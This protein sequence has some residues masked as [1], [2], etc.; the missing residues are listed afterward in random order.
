M[1]RRR[2]VSTL[3][4]VPMILSALPVLGKDKKPEEPVPPPNQFIAKAPGNYLALPHLHM[5][6]MEERNR[7]FRALDLEV[8][9]LPKDE[10]NLGLAR[11]AKKPI[12]AALQEEFSNYSWEAFVDAKKGPDIAKQIV[13]GVVERISHAKLQDVLIKKLLL[14]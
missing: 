13:M 12:M 1:T 6:V 11:S 10:E 3:L 9:L 5:T 8:W 7:Q 4:L 14:I 2:I